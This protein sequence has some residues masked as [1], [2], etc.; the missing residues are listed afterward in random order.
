MTRIAII[1]AGMAGLACAQAL[2]ASGHTPVLFDKGRGAGGRMATRRIATAAGEAMFDHGAQYFT[3]RDPAFQ[4]QVAQW[5]ADGVVARWPAAGPDAWLGIPAMNAPVKQLARGC[6]VRWSARADALGRGDGVWRVQGDGIDAG[7]FDTVLLAVP[8]ENA[9]PLL[10]PWQPDMA[11]RALA[12]PA[13]PCWTLMAAFTGPVAYAADIMRDQGAIGWA[14]RNSAKPGRTGPEAWVIQAG[15][16]WSAA[17]LEET[18]DAIVPQLLR[19]FAACVGGAL[20]DTLA[21]MAHRW[22]Y[23][24]SGSAGDGVLWNGAIGLGVC[25]D[26]LLGPRVELAWLSGTR[27]A[28]MAA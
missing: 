17:H 19:A 13:Q 21:A 2:R 3:A 26:W 6:D 11:A 15:P 14:A 9:A 1:G 27:L 20:P 18:P 7:P 5:A 10:Q 28:G 12:T 25:G 8:A 4:A 16:D 22:R 24:R 23:A